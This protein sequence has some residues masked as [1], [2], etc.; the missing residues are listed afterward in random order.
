MTAIDMMNRLSTIVQELGVAYHELARLEEIAR[1]V[2][3]SAERMEALTYTKYKAQHEK[4]DDFTRKMV[5]ETE[6]V[7]QAKL[8]TIQCQAKH[9]AHWGTV[10]TLEKEYDMLR[11]GLGMERAKLTAGI[12]LGNHDTGG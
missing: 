7:Y 12:E 5:T 4:S 1:T 11:S 8:N 3:L 6:E 9:R 10:K 2:E